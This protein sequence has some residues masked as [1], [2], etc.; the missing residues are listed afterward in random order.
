[1]YMS[2]PP[3]SIMI[4][5]DSVHFEPMSGVFIYVLQKNQKKMQNIRK[6]HG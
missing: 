1:M 4:F 5:F 3:N 6:F 2:H